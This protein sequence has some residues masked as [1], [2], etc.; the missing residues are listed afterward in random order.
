MSLAL[1][2]SLSL[3]KDLI[4]ED[5][6]TIHL[7]KTTR[8]SVGDL[9]IRHKKDSEL[10]RIDNLTLPTEL[11]TD[12]AIK[13]WGQNIHDYEPE[14]WEFQYERYRYLKNI[15]NEALYKRYEDIRRNF[16][17]LTSKERNIIPINSFLSS[18]YWF[19]KEHQT[20]Y[21]LFLK[22]LSLPAPLSLVK[23]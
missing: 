16:E 15:N 2:G 9:F 7:L 1:F 3:I 4:V 8:F 18:W 19:R 13:S 17:I 10:K 23:K 20:R 21:E 11:P 12:Q 22:K 6:K 14:F 5:N